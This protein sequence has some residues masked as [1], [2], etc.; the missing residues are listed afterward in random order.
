MPLSIKI[1]LS[2]LISAFLYYLFVSS[3]LKKEENIPSFLLPF[4]RRND[5]NRRA[6]VSRTVDILIVEEI[7]LTLIVFFLGGRNFW[8]ATLMGLVGSF[9]VL[10]TDVIISFKKVVSIINSYSATVKLSVSYVKKRLVSDIILATASGFIV[11]FICSIL[12]FAAL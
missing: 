4:G 5:E 12:H 11:G 1:V 6:K 3:R 8:L 2:G 9:S 7:I 10:I